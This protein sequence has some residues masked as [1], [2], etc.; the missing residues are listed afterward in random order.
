MGHSDRYYAKAYLLQ[1]NSWETWEAMR[2]SLR[3]PM[4]RLVYLQQGDAELG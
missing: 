3:H 4:N 1:L 2:S